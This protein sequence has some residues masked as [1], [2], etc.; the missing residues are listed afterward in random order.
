MR[1]GVSNRKL[2]DKGSAARRVG[3][4]LPLVVGQ[5]QVI[6]AVVRLGLG[7]KARSVVK[8][9]VVAIAKVRKGS[10][11]LHL[12]RYCPEKKKYNSHSTLTSTSLTLIFYN[13]S[14]TILS[15]K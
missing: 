1:D 10:S 3:A 15:S 11:A 4:P 7:R 13:L 5:L 14:H 9:V 2:L 6:G 8:T 12:R